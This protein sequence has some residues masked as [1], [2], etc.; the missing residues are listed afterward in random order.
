MISLK[1]HGKKIAMLLGKRY[2][3]EEAGVPLDFFR[4]RGA[5]VDVISI[6]KGELQG[7]YRRRTIDVDRIVEEVDTTEYD[8]LIIPGGR[9]PAWLR[10]SE[11]A[12]RFVREFYE[13]GKPLA[14]ICHGPQ[15]LAEAGVLKGKRITGYHKIKEE[16][17]KAGAL[18]YD[19][20]VI[21]DG[22]LVTSREPG[23]LDVFNE[24]LLKLISS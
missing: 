8:A 15:I 14:A 13:S 22:N 3:D 6:S 11:A 9:S 24:T 1:L 21:V 16:M 17:L 7:L 19:E 2:Q 5:Q 20:P 12:V 23:D 18:F 10:K 4:A